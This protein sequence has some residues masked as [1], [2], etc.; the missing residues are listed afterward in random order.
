[1]LI[2]I[3]LFTG[4]AFS[5]DIRVCVKKDGNN[6]I[7]E[8]LD[9]EK[10]IMGVLSKEMGPLWPEE[11]LK[12]QAVVSRTLAVYMINENRK[13]DCSYDIENS[14]S[15]QVYNETD[16]E[17]IEN[18]VKETE[19]E[20]LTYK[21]NIVQV[22]F[23]A[24]CGG[25]TAKAEDVWGGYYPHISSVDDPYCSSSPYYSWEKSFSKDKLSRIL[26]EAS[27]QAKFSKIFSILPI[28]GISI[29]SRDDTGRVTILKLIGKNGKIVSLTGHEFRMMVNQGRKVFF[30]SPDI[31]PSTKFNVKKDGDYFIFTGE[32]YGHGVGMCQWG[33][34]KMA[35]EGFNYREIL[36]YYFP[37][38]ELS[39]IE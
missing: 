7:V 34:R 12:A 24:N 15:H 17:K 35:E 6:A 2:S 30:D 3:L 5:Q 22:F 29:E 33:A 32:G 8:T 23:H 28:Q 36:K 9:I 37:E 11:A 27:Y 25:K 14:T 1:M 18:A 31:I 21:G 10:Y 38:M 20:I 16:C 4:I 26:K 13:N 39:K 19:G